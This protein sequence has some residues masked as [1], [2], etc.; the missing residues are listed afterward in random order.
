MRPHDNCSDN[1]QDS[2]GRKAVKC[3]HLIRTLVTNPEELHVH[4]TR[5]LPFDCAIL[6]AHR[7]GIVA[8]HW[9]F[10]LYVS[11]VFED[12]LKNN[13]CLAIVE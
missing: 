5:P 2:F 8:M 3:V 7:G 10:R 9:S 12:A 11:H 6:D 4:Q 13:T 1:P